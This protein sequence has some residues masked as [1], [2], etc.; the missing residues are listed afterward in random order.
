MEE[1]DSHPQHLLSNH[2]VTGDV[3][4]FTVKKGGTTLAE[5]AKRHHVDVWDLLFLNRHLYKEITSHSRLMAGTMLLIPQ[6]PHTTSTNT[7]T[8]NNNTTAQDSNESGTADAPKYYTAKENDTPRKIAKMFQLNCDDLIDANKARLPGLAPSSRLR[9]GTKVRV[10]HLLVPEV[11]YQPYAHWSFPDDNFEEGEPGYMMARKLNRRRG[12]A[13]NHRPVLQSLA[14]P[15]AE[16]EQPPLLLFPPE[17]TAI[18]TPMVQSLLIRDDQPKPPRKPMGPYL[19]FC[20]EQRQILQTNKETVAGMSMGEISQQIA[21]LWRDL[22]D[23]DK[24]PYLESAHRAKMEYRHAKAS[25]ELAMQQCTT[26][27][28]QY[29]PSHSGFSAAESHDPKESLGRIDLFNAVVKLKPGAITEGSN[30]TYWYVRFIIA[31]PDQITMVLCISCHW[32]S[33]SKNYLFRCLSRWC[34]NPFLFANDLRYV[35]TYI[36]D[37]QWCHLAPM[38][39]VGV[40]GPDKPKAEGRVKYMLVDERLGMEVDI[41]AIYCIPIKA[42]FMKKTLDADREEWDVIDDGSIP[43]ERR[44]RSRVRSKHEDDESSS[45]SP[46]DCSR[47]AEN[48]PALRSLKP[49][50]ICKAPQFPSFPPLK[51]CF[52][53][54][55]GNNTVTVR[56]KGEGIER[57]GRGRP[58]GSI[59]T[60]GVDNTPVTN[61]SFDSSPEQIKRGKDGQERSRS[62]NRRVSLSHEAGVS[63]KD[64]CHSSTNSKTEPATPSSIQRSKS[65]TRRKN[66]T[67]RRAQGE[68]I[69]ALIAPPESILRTPLLIHKCDAGE[70]VSFRKRKSRDTP[71]DDLDQPHPKRLS[72]VAYVESGPSKKWKKS[73][74]KQR[75]TNQT[76]CQSSGM[77]GSYES[78]SKRQKTAIPSNLNAAR[79]RRAAAPQFLGEPSPLAKVPEETIPYNPPKRPGSSIGPRN[80][81]VCATISSSKV[82]AENLSSP[83]STPKRWHPIRET[84]NGKITPRARRTTD[85]PTER[86]I[87]P[88]RS[89]TNEHHAQVNNS[90]LDSPRP[91]RKA[92]PNFSLLETSLLQ[93]SASSQ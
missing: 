36:P 84:R 82:C 35:L 81:K 64:K 27:A 14:I 60:R 30:Y 18:S 39:P 7:T 74:K 20:Q 21:Q 85:P 22:S 80:A 57:R 9:Q 76:A 58:K 25:Y 33:P 47:G 12:S 55:T 34:F 49:K 19:I 71:S 72:R 87:S 54:G 52:P 68:V 70:S 50:A 16:Y 65:N 1:E 45:V 8:N 29:N 56:L 77:N 78:P 83:R 62:S 4:Y 41:S 43:S 17:T 92:A 28:K 15:I 48:Y 10:S 90:A 13:A 32:N 93:R 2:I 69:E 86:R 73:Q 46:S 24:L 3:T 63:T 42:R 91:K 51:A 79:P 31:L 23:E 5:L 6:L 40:F 44:S 61:V 59:T 67:S 53:W 66:D 37:L 11:V 75:L 38:I 89:P 88:R 26:I